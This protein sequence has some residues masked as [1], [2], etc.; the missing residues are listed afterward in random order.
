[1]PSL[2]VYRVLVLPLVE[3]NVIEELRDAIKLN[4]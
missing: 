1:M 4:V 3:L 2:Y